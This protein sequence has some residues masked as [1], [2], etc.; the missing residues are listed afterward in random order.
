MMELRLKDPWKSATKSDTSLTNGMS[1]G[2]WAYRCML[3][4]RRL[5][6]W[7][8]KI[9]S[10]WNVSWR[11]VEYAGSVVGLLW[12]D[13][14]KQ[15]SPKEDLLSP[16]NNVVGLKHGVQDD[17][18]VRLDRERSKHG[19]VK[20]RKVFLKK[21]HVNCTFIL[22]SSLVMLMWLKAQILGRFVGSW[23]VNAVAGWRASPQYL[24]GRETAFWSAPL[25][26]GLQKVFQHI[27]SCRLLD[28]I[29]CCNSISPSTTNNN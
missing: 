14:C 1:D 18:D 6:R 27:W 17:F 10:W 8:N 7:P 24:N 28:A 12:S 4:L 20:V 11:T 25:V 29:N 23:L 19:T 16:K 21:W 22:H 26:Y 13:L 15:K 2:G 5:Q 3:K 9:F